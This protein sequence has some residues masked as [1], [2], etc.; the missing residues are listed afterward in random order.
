MQ[1]KPKI[2]WRS[3]G[4][5]LTL[6]TAHKEHTCTKCPQP[7]E[8]GEPYCTAIICGSGVSGMK[9]VE[10]VHVGCLGEL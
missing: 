10:R 7:I 3:N 6:R 9:D 2:E 1:S 8:K 4:K 5:I